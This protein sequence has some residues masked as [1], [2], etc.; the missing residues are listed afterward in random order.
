M[1]G[2]AA[3]S[4]V[5]P[6]K[7]AIAVGIPD[8]PLARG[9][10]WVRLTDVAEMATGHTPSRN[11]P[12]Y[13]DGDIAWIGI[14]DARVFHGRRITSTFQTVTQAG[15][16]NSASVLLPANTVCLS[17]TASVG[18]VTI[19]DRPMATSQDFVNWKCSDALAPEF[20]MYLLIAERDSLL[21]FGKGTTHTTIYFPEAKALS[22]GLPPVAEQRRIVA[23]IEELFS[24]LDAGVAALERV[25]ANLKRY[26]AAVLKAAVEGRL[27]EEWR[28]RHPATE[29]A[30]KLLERI[31]AE[32]RAKWEQDQLRKFKEAGKTPPKGWREKYEEPPS[33]HAPFP[34]QL[35]PSW[36]WAGSLQLCT[37]IE[38]GST[39]PPDEMQAGSGEVPFI[40]VYNLTFTGALDFTIKPTF[41]ARQTHRG[42]LNRSRAI[43]GDVLMN[44]V[45]P[46]LGKVSIVP[47]L[48]PEWNTN[49]AI[50]SFRAGPGITNRYLATCLLADPVLQWITSQA[51]ATAGQHNISVSMS[52]ALPLPLPPLAEQAEIVAE[53]DRRLSVADAAETQVEHALQRAARLRQAILKR[54]FEGE[55]VPQDPSDRPIVVDTQAGS[56]PRSCPPASRV[57]AKVH[58]LGST[59]K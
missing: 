44:I 57:K 12:K 35:P 25:R 43:P 47:D 26:R 50:V 28:T 8:M 39:P 9:W 33:P 6:G 46:P 20:L 56:S 16:D 53:V 30:A 34:F 1:S 22:I 13:W 5:T 7:Y 49:Q 4:D 27:T 42:R 18:Y 23:K 31:L 11:H 3:T 10:K 37:S 21:K 19:M 14:K 59:K 24:D 41:I 36:S 45:G 51:K 29:P 2:R 52:R 32:R 55:L 54:A 40:K 17:R 58:S 38:S 15:L 48:Y